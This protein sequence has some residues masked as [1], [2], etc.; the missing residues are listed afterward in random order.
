VSQ[1]VTNINNIIK[2]SKNRKAEVLRQLYEKWRL[3]RMPREEERKEVRNYIFAT[4]TSTTAN[5]SLPWKNRTHIPKLCQIRENLH[6]NYLDALFPNDD[7][8]E[9][10]GND[11]ESVELSKKELVKTYIRNKANL[12]GFKQTMAQCLYDY[13]DNGECFAEVIWVNETHYDPETDEEET[14]YMG[15]KVL[16][17]SPYDHFYNLASIS[18]TKSPKFTR[19]IKNTG[20]LRKEMKVRHDLQFD[21]VEFKKMTEFR[22]TM[23]G[24]SHEDLNKA[25]GYYSDGFGTYSEYL[26]SGLIEIIEYEGDLYD[27]ETDTLYENRIITIADGQ[28]VLRDIPNPN[29]LGTDNKAKVNWR[30]RPDNLAGMGPLDN[31]VGMQYRIDHLENL[32]ADALDL[33][34]H[35]PV[36][37]HGDVEPFIWGPGVQILLPE[38]GDVD[39]MPP[40]AA[41]FQVNN[42]IAYLMALMEEMAGAPKEAMG[43]R[44]PGE[45]TAFEVQSLQNSASR[46]FNNKILKFSTEFMERLLNLML[47]VS[48]RN[49]NTKDVL[50][51]VDT[52]LGVVEFINITKDD[53]VAKGKLRP[54]GARHHA[55]KAQL[56]QNLTSLMGSPVAQIIA[57]HMSGTKLATLVEETLGL[58]KHGLFREN[59]A[60]SE[61]AKTQRLVSTEQQNMQDE[62][63]IDVSP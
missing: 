35:P 33:T 21:E 43:F 12:S 27:D 31:L 8:L 15:P 45:K 9:W 24:F 51:V 36:K 54:V 11:E 50:R 2:G 7:W 61:Q 42:E 38:D 10:E 17:I 37:I 40:N 25:D 16:R 41:A 22:R 29:W 53:I 23:A 4:D 18:Y 55:A 1:S 3:Q 62:S 14:T 47:E 28:F 5:Q 26:G 63:M 52:D 59:I 46:I 49:L 20:E 39:Q 56:M 58:Q 6:A 57:P 30:D 32:K 13:I 34:I 44:T 60:V 19:Y 48:R